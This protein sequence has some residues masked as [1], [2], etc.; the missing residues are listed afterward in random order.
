MTILRIIYNGADMP[1]S[2]VPDRMTR[3]LLGYG[4]F[5]L[6][7]AHRRV[8][9][10]PGRAWPYTPATCLTDEHRGEWLDP[11]TLVCTGCGL[12]CT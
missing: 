5:P 12:D 4:H 3:A 11:S 8:V 1:V 10:V 6:D 2:E 9:L 7:L